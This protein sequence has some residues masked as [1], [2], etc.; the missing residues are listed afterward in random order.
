MID[1]LPLVSII[2]PA[3]NR[4]DYLEEVILSVLNQGYPNIEYIV[5]DDGSIDNTVDL[6]KKYTNRIFWETQKNIGE[7]LT[8][9]KGINKAKGEIIGI[10]NSD[11]PL[12]PGAIKEIVQMFQE[13]P[14]LFVIYPD[15][16]MIDAEGHLIET[17]ST[18][19]YD[20]KNMVRWHHCIPG[21][22]TLF[23]RELIISLGGRDPSFRFV[24]DYDFW[25]RA[26]LIGP[27]ARIP[28]ILATFRWYAGGV[29]SASKGKEM[30]EEHIRLVNKI[31]F[32]PNLPI[33]IK[34]LKN[35]AYSSANYVAGV[36]CGEN[37]SLKKKYYLQALKYS[38]IKYLGEYRRRAGE[39]MRVF[40]PSLFPKIRRVLK[41]IGR[42]IK[43][44][45]GC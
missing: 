1:Q 40:F 26:G 27:F 42:V 10:V 36:V 25:L 17:I 44:K 16:N 9:N 13:Q 34:K 11:D 4:A 29:S 38:P 24:A 37:Y 6:L 30:A 5:L 22:G 20:Y 8:V 39:M 2:T 32:L 31:F 23:K 41:W 43:I 33:N 12:L 35:E 7:T 21:P 18:Y 15:W 19:E 45:E 3:Y 14:D 28:K